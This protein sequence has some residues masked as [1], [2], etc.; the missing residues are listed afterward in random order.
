M[1]RYSVCRC[2]SSWNIIW[3][4]WGCIARL[5]AEFSLRLYFF[6]FEEAASIFSQCWHL[7][8]ILIFRV[9]LHL[10][11]TVAVLLHVVCLLP[12]LIIIKSGLE[13][14]L[15]STAG[16]K[17]QPSGVSCHK[18]FKLWAESCRKLVFCLFVWLVVVVVIVYI[19]GSSAKVLKARSLIYLGQLTLS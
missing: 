6:V 5:R 3:Q 8:F 19:G 18:A 13:G 14:K 17:I 16:N 11:G 15:K 2:G 10:I 9:C 4:D 7:I 1:V 12:T